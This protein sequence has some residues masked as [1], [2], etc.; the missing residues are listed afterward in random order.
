VKLSV[1]FI[2]SS[3]GAAPTN[4]GSINLSTSAA[5]DVEVAYGNSVL[6]ATG[7]GYKLRVIEYL[8]VQP[9]APAGQPADYWYN[10][11]ARE[12][13]QTIE[14]AAASAAA[15]WAWNG[16]GA[17]NIYVNNSSSG[18]CSFIGSGVSIALGSTIFTRGT[19][20]HEIGHFFDLSHTHANDPK[21]SS[22]TPPD[23]LSS[24]LTNGDGL[25]ETIPDHP[26]YTRD[27]LSQ[28]NFGAVYS[29]L[30]PAQQA[31]VNTSWLNVMSYHNEAAFLD[32]QMDYW[33]ANANTPRQAVCTGRTWFVRPDGFDHPTYSLN[34]GLTPGT[35]FGGAFQTLERGLAGLV[36]PNF[37]HLGDDVVLLRGGNYTYSSPDPIS[38]P[39]TLA[40]AYGPVTITRP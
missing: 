12:N 27:Q 11:D 22:F 18:S 29:A 21:C 9:P 13:R 36:D 33:T 4:S 2:M 24:A 5:F 26:C 38:T 8:N 19:V 17:L 23:P 28:A 35:G 20:L 3:T 31:A 30:T 15:T 10:I 7:R 32:I 25:V 6:D 40:A 16:A 37:V 34:A 39:G 14:N 1:K